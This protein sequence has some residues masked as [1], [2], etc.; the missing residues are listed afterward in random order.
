MCLTLMATLT[1]FGDCRQSTENVRTDW[2]GLRWISL[3]ETRAHRFV[4]CV[5]E[6]AFYTLGSMAPYSRRTY[7]NMNT[8][9]SCVAILKTH[10]IIVYMEHRAERMSV[11][12]KSHLRLWQ[13][14]RNDSIDRNWKAYRNIVHCTFIQMGE[15]VWRMNEDWIETEL[16]AIAWICLCGRDVYYSIII[17]RLPLSHR[18][19]FSAEMNV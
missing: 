10:L 12:R 19:T 8:K 6:Y 7:K 17:L 11:S 5:P 15:C 2:A 4:F 3:W 14:K 9:I 16:C 1:Q 13:H 18:G